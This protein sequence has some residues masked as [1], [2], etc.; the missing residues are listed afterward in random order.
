MTRVAWCAVCLLPL[1]VIDTK[2]AAQPTLVLREG[3]PV[4]LQTLMVLSSDKSRKGEVLEF[5]VVEPVR[6]GG[7]VVIPRGA[8]ARGR[9]LEAKGKGLFGRP[10]TLQL[11]IQNVELITHENAELSGTRERTPS[12][13]TDV[14]A[15]EA[16]RQLDPALHAGEPGAVIGLPMV[17]PLAIGAAVE[18]GASIRLLPGTLMTAYIRK[19]VSLDIAA[20]KTV[21][22][23]RPI[24]GTIYVGLDGH[25]NWVPLYCGGMKL[26]KLRS[27][28]L[29]RLEIPPVPTT[30]IPPATTA[31]SSMRQPVGATS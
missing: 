29:M 1:V 30:F 2:S 27:A 13:S 26:G 11:G 10:G 28:E 31:W 16:A 12:S 7:L 6:L 17:L 25:H 19:D 3:T 23:Q 22:P 18:P 24:V 21:Q 14:N 5:S 4:Q 8:K 9:V 20:L 15:M